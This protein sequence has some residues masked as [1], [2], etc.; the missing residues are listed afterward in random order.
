MRRVRKLPGAFACKQPLPASAGSIAWLLVGST[1]TL[2][3]LPRGN[4]GQ[5]RRVC[6][7]SGCSYAAPKPCT[8]LLRGCRSFVGQE[9]CQWPMP[10]LAWL[11][12]NQ[13]FRAENHLPRTADFFRRRKETSPPLAPSRSKGSS[14]RAAPI[15]R[16]ASALPQPKE[17]KHFPIDQQGRRRSDQSLQPLRGRRGG[18]TG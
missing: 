11:L 9:P 17:G 7:S 18:R 6:R 8:A 5:A 1:K 16:K 15:Q 12:E 13:L 14:Q 4:L 2:S 3:T 10:G